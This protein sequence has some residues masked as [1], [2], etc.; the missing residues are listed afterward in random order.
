MNVQCVDFILT[1][2]FVL[3]ILKWQKLDFE[4]WRLKLISWAT[5]NHSSFQW[6]VETHQ[7]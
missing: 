4:S 1:F 3:G 5:L 7:G 6:S 2:H